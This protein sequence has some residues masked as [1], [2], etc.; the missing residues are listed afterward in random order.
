[1]GQGTVTEGA[2]YE[3]RNAITRYRQHSWLRDPILLV[4]LNANFELRARRVVGAWW[5]AP[6]SSHSTVSL[7]NFSMRPGSILVA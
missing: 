6:K 7:G 2:V 3:I 4:A 5:S 1:M